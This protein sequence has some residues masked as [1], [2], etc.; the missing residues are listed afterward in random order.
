MPKDYLAS[1]GR[2]DRNNERIG[3]AALPF[4]FMMNALRLHRGFARE[5]FSA[6]TGLP[7]S[8][9][10]SKIDALIARGLLIDDAECIVPTPLGQRFLNDVLGEFLD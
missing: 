3:T 8:V 9:V 4:E 7:W 5:L 1:A 2:C 6:R 10:A